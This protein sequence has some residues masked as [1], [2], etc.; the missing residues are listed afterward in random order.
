MMS[1]I[2]QKGDKNIMIAIKKPI[3]FIPSASMKLPFI[4]DNIER[5]EP[6]KGQGK[7]VTYLIKQTSSG[8]FIETK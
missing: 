3:G 8:L 5:V 4:N 7:F 2:I 6:Q 1:A